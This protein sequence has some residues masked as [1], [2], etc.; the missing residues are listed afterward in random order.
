MQTS[1]FDNQGVRKEYTCVD[2]EIGTMTPIKYQAVDHP[3]WFI[4]KC[5]KCC[6]S[7]FDC[8][9][10]IHKLKGK[11]WSVEVEVVLFVQGVN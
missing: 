6:K 10:P 2:C 9:Y 11:K 8:A 4:S 3:E 1:K 5:K 7:K